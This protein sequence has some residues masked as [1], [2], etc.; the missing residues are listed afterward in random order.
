MPS[1]EDLQPYVVGGTAACFAATCIHPMDV[2]KVRLQLHAMQNPGQ[3]SPGFVGVIRGMIQRSGIL[4]IYTGLDAS[5]MRQASYGTARI[6]LNRSFAEKAKAWNGSPNLPFHLK[7]G[8]GMASGA[9][10][11]CIG[12]PM[13]LALV[14]LQ[15]DSMKPVEERRNYRGVVDAVMRTAREEGIASL[16]KGVAPN[17]LRGMAMNVGQ[18]AVYDQAKEVMTKVFRDADPKKPSMSTQLVCAAIS[19][20]TA[21]AFSLPFDMIKSR[22]QDQKPKADGK[23]PYSGVADCAVKV[24]RNEGLSALWTGFSAYYFRCAPFAMLI[25]L[26]VEF[27]DPRYKSTF[28]KPAQAPQGQATTPNKEV[29]AGRAMNMATS[30]NLIFGE[31]DSEAPK[32]RVRRAWTDTLK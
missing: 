22:L 30:T 4:S 11:V 26:T 13:D 10:A 18:L 24:V 2:A 19:G 21:A 5:M 23:L 7:V 31:N 14:R 12:T 1:A 32:A 15:S 20:F 9:V 8:A 27:L 16:W 6:G 3:P 25:L 17:I 29:K 28:G